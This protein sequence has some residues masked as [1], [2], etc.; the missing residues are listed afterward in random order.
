ME[1]ILVAGGT[2]AMG[3]YLVPKLVARGYEVTV[4]HNDARLLER[5]QGANYIKT[6]M[7]D[8]GAVRELL[9]AGYDGVIDFMVYDTGAFGRYAPLYLDKTGQYISLSSYR[10]FANEE[11]PIRETSPQL[12]NACKDEEFRYSNDYPIY[13]AKGE[14]FLRGWHGKNYTIVRPAITYSKRRCQLINLERPQIFGAIK[15]NEPIVL[16]NEAMN[17]QATMSWAGDVAEMLA[18]LFFNSAAFGEDFNVSTAEHR[19][20]GEIFSVFT[21]IIERDSVEIRFYR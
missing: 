9:G 4:T 3:V 7:Y 18:R 12:I 10:V 20:W 21:A 16:C 2:G 6:D 14:C 1:K 8:M 15:K 5:A 19:T 13:K 17:V 11:T